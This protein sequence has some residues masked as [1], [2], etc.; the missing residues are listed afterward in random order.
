MPNKPKE[1]GPCR[2][3]DP[4]KH[5]AAT[6]YGIGTC[7]TCLD[8]PE[9]GN[10]CNSGAHDSGLSEAANH[11]SSSAVGAR[12]SGLRA[13]WISALRRG[14]RL[15]L[16][17]L[18]CT[19]G[20]LARRGDSGSAFSGSGKLARCRERVRDRFV[21]GRNSA[22]GSVGG[23]NGDRSRE[24]SLTAGLVDDRTLV[25]GVNHGA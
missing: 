8:E 14:S 12:R 3:A 13:S 20:R 11:S 2:Q 15:A 10:T 23:G 21:G 16:R 22:T 17:N 5:C 4:K 18:G 7:A 6:S 19:G 25:H 1:T 24:E 9:D